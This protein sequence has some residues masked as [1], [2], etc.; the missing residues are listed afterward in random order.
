LTVETL[1]AELGEIVAGRRP[2]RERDDE[3]ILFWHR[4]L[5]TCDVALGAL[6]LDRATERGIGTVLDYR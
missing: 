6:L 3:R 5:A 4:G 1:H 2:G